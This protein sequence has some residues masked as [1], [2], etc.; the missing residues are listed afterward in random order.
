MLKAI[1]TKY[2]GYRFRSRLEARWAVFFDTLGATWAY[3]DQG[4]DLGPAGYYLPDFYLTLHRT[5]WIEIKPDEPSLHEFDK[6]R[7]LARQADGCVFFAAGTPGSE[8]IWLV[9]PGGIITP[10]TTDGY[11]VWC[12]LFALHQP[13][14]KIVCPTCSKGYEAARSARFEHGEQPIIAPA[15]LIPTKQ[16]AALWDGQSSWYH[17]PNAKGKPR[18]GRGPLQNWRGIMVAEESLC[19]ECKAVRHA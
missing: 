15:P 17:I 9:E 11:P 16:V 14:C 2:K 4:Y 5:V 6:A 3:E 19:W 13:V 8:K 10:E 18:C 7:E 1:E 12:D